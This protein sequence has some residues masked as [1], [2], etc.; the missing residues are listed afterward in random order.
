MGF[1]VTEAL[2]QKKKE[3]EREREREKTDRKRFVDCTR[4]PLLLQN[5]GHDSTNHNCIMDLGQT[6]KNDRPVEK[7][8]KTRELWEQFKDF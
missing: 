5:V 8:L 2:L 7:Q 3:K 1:F 6:T 4:L